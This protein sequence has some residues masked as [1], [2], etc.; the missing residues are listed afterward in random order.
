MSIIKVRDRLKKIKKKYIPSD[1]N[2]KIGIGI[3]CSY[4]NVGIGAGLKDGAGASFELNEK[5]EFILKHGAASMG[6]GVETIVALIASEVT[7]IP[8]NEIKVLGNITSICPDGEETTA[9]RQTFVTGNCV[10]FVSE[11]LNKKIINTIKTYYNIDEKF[12]FYVNN[13]FK[14]KLDNKFVSWKD[15]VKKT[16][17]I[18]ENY[19]YIPPITS[20]LSENN[21]SLKGEDNL[22]YKIHYS[23]TFTTQGV[24]LEVDKTTGSYKIL[25]IIAAQDLGKAIH[26]LQ[27]K[28]QV[29]G[30]ISMGLGYAS[31]EELKTNEGYIITNDLAKLKLPKIINTPEIEV[32]LIEKPQMEGPFGAKGMGELPVNPMGPAISNALYNALG[33]RI[34]SLPITK[35][36]ILKALHNK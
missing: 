2:K 28:E 21:L 34:C 7:K 31:S 1:S 9:S 35:E 18:K 10:K 17:I 32:I 19:E 8:Y 15:F 30:G 22:K 23:Y 3:A 25:K 4:K 33:I 20:R 27:A 6:Q 16:G 12:L 36:K 29:I 5:G 14:N 11:K 13:G 26:P 24:I